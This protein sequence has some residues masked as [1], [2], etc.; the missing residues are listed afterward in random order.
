[1]DEDEKDTLEK[2]WENKI[3]D[4]RVSCWRFSSQTGGGAAIRDWKHTL[5]ITQQEWSSDSHSRQEGTQRE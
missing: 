2:S 3:V 1:M 5:E 4:A